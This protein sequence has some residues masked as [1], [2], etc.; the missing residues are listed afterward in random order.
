MNKSASLFLE[1]KKNQL[2]ALL[3]PKNAKQC[4]TAYETLK[5]L[6]IT[7][8]IAFRSE[9]A[10]DG[11]RAVLEKYP[12]A[13]VLAGT[14][15]TQKQA[16]TAIELGVAGIVSADYIPAVVEICVKNN[17]M[18]IPGGLSD[19]GK[20]LV[21]KAGLYECELTE[22]REKIPC[23][24][25][26]KLF[27]AITAT[28]SNVELTKSWKGP[29]QG[30]TVIYTGGISLNNLRDVVQSDPD[31]I[32][33]G[34]ALTRSTDDPEKM[35]DE[36]EQWLKIIHRPDK[37]ETIQSKQKPK[38]KRTPQ[39]VVTFGEILLRL[40]PPDNLRFIQTKTYDSTFGGAEANAAVAF[41]NYGL[42][43]CFM[44]ALPEH[45]IG[46]SVVNG[47]RKYGVDTT[48][49]LRQGK[50]VGIYFL[51]CG[52][53]QRPSKVIYDRAGSSISEI[54]P[55]QID[56]ENILREAA[57][58]HWSGI[59][60]A[61]SDSAA[62]VTLEALQAAK[63]TGVSVSVDLNYRKKLWSKVKAGKVMTNLMEYVDIAIGNEE[64]AECFFGIK[65]GK[66]DVDAGKLDLEGYHRVAKQMMRKFN[67]KKV[68]ITL[69]ESISAS[70]NHWSACLYNGKN[71]LESKKYHIHIIDRVGGGDSFS[72]G[73]IFGILSGKSDEE[74]LEFGVAASCLKQTIHGD[75][76]LVSIQEV[77]RLTGGETAGRIQR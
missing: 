6:G 77:E 48:K 26:Y 4:I 30:L 14:V 74:A 7:L 13:L 52:A 65:A 31:G 56:W 16:E 11:I 33:C 69:R 66:T 10:E 57:W 23:Q 15:M 5:S 43:S 8:E 24:W 1:L 32:F 36:A 35:K 47:L 40:S 9:T 22:L 12:D 19:V 64:D 28:K 75:F 2:I 44:T 73:F 46:Q 50:R 42:K 51:E 62:E 25:I 20:Q 39:K 58:F 55:G 21:Q 37:K 60:P 54:K 53:S 70:D 17:I 34:S 49:I 63:K 68:A 61:L 27:P 72:S 76:N 45:E 29:Y 71:F 59:T 41:A 38:T 18:C 3:T 67:F